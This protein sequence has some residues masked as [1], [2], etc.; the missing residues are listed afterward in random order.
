MMISVIIPTLSKGIQED[1]L[2][3]LRRLLIEYLPNQTYNNYEAIVYCDGPNEKVEEMIESLNDSRIKVYSTP[4]T[5]GKW[6]HPQTRMGIQL[7]GGNFFLRMNDDNYPYEAYL[8]TLKSGFEEG[9]G[10]VYA[11]VLFKGD[12]RKDHE[13]IFKRKSFAGIRNELKDTLPRD[14]A[15]TLASCNIDCMNYMIRMNLAKKFVDFWNDNYDADWK[16]IEKLLEEN[17][18]YRFVNKIIGDKL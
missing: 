3:K 13:K 17:T 15:G 1:H 14:N 18:K 2:P 11:R 9:V 6:G 10:I 12:A 8:E 16:F 5:I 7:A 4:E